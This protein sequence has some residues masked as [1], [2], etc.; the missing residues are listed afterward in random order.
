MHK[1]DKN[2]SATHYCASRDWVP[3]RTSEDACKHV[4]IEP[5]TVPWLMLPLA[6]SGSP[7]VA[8]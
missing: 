8:L 7:P 4:Q 1:I 5:D 2:C 3:A 6:P